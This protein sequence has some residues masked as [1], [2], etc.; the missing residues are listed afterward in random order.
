MEFN[1]IETSDLCGPRRTSRAEAL[2]R[3]R[4][5]GVP[6]SKSVTSRTAR[7]GSEDSSPS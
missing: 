5:A 2:A 7:L 3:Q 1:R 6:V 4:P